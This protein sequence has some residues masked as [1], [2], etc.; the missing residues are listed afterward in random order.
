[1]ATKAR[2]SYEEKH[3]RRANM[4]ALVKAGWTLSA[5]ADRFGMC[6]GSVEEA[7]RQAGVA[8]PRMP[9]GPTPASALAIL[10]DLQNTDDTIAQIAERRSRHESSV[11]EVLSHGRKEGLLFP[12]RPVGTKNE[13][14]VDA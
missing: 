8:I 5:V 6:E 11:R 13:M 10:A 1:M 2:M 7:C 4:S 12:N 9:L 14:T 3:E